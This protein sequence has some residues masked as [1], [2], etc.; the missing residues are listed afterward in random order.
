M[1]HLQG[2]KGLVDDYM[3]KLAGI[4]A[5][6]WY[7]NPDF[8]I[9]LQ[10]EHQLRSE[11][12]LE[13]APGLFD[14]LQ[15]LSP[16]SPD[17]FLSLPK[18]VGKYWGVYASLHTMEDKEPG[19]NIGS[20]TDSGRGYPKRVSHYSNK[21]HPLLPRYV[22]QAY[23]R[24]YDLAHIGLLCWAPIPKAPL[25]PRTRLLFI[26]L[27]STFTHLF[28]SAIPTIMDQLW[29]DLVPWSRD[30]VLWR[31]LNSHIPFSEG[32]DDVGM[33]EEQLVRRAEKRKT[34]KVYVRRQHYLKNLEHYRQLY[35]NERARDIDAFRAKKAK[36]ARSWVARHRAK[37]REVQKRS[38]AKARAEQRYRCVTCDKSFT[39]SNKLKNHYNSQ[40]HKDNLSG[41]KVRSLQRQRQ[42]DTRRRNKAL[43]R[44]LCVECDYAAE[45][46]DSLQVHYASGKHARRV[47]ELKQSL[48]ISPA[49]NDSAVGR[50]PNS[51]HV[52]VSVDAT[53]RGPTQSLVGAVHGAVLPDHDFADDSSTVTG[54]SQATDMSDAG[55]SPKTLARYQSSPEIIDLTGDDDPSAYW[56][57]ASEFGP[58]RMAPVMSRKPKLLCLPQLVKQTG[59]RSS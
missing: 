35:E 28:Y 20:G 16:P 52:G 8:T 47:L 54:S 33:T 7:I 45:S 31:P 9:L 59:A 27:E 5:P 24:G 32:V 36:Q 37:V 38:K 44:Y 14:V 49:A 25:N 3:M 19:L 13:F 26:A 10:E 18:P 57:P 29:T 17:F 15:S 4:D 58:F 50:C 11:I 2:L 55:D 22:R 43:K 56:P 41:G 23:D 48:D 42:L 30:D 21:K 12:H 1:S 51:S 53:V 40:R 46:S 39:D 34:R 6:D